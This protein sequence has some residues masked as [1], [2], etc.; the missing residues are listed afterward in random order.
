TEVLRHLVRQELL[1]ELFRIHEDRAAESHAEQIGKGACP[2]RNQAPK[3]FGAIVRERYDEAAYF[4]P[5]HAGSIGS[6]DQRA[7]RAP[8]NDDR[9]AAELVERLE[10]RDMREPAR[11]ATAERKRKAL[12]H[13]APAAGGNSRALAAS[14]RTSG[15]IARAFLLVAVPSRT[16]P[17]MP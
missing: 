6:A 13:C 3:H 2:R 1:A 4:A 16:R 9:F 11:A 14:G 8:G 5:R 17:T 7:A 15:A 10:H 12:A